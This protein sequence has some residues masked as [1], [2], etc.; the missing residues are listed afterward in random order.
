MYLRT[1]EPRLKFLIIRC[2]AVSTL[3]R[4]LD[5][6]HGSPSPPVPA[7]SAHAA[8]RESEPPIR[9]L[10]RRRWATDPTTGTSL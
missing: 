9:L 5:A 4:R 8:S 6:V 3:K 7:Y 10:F 2:V 1:H